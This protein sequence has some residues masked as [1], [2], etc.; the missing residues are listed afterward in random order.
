MFVFA[1]FH[2]QFSSSG[3]L[4]KIPFRLKNFW[5]I[6]FRFSPNRRVEIK[7]SQTKE[8]DPQHETLKTALNVFK[9]QNSHH[10]SRKM[11]NHKMCNHVFKTERTKTEVLKIDLQLSGVWK[12]KFRIEFLRSG[13]KKKKKKK[14]IW[15]TELQ[16]FRTTKTTTWKPK[17]CRKIFEVLIAKHLK[18]EILFFLLF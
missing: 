10:K 4:I 1:F 17:K 13:I 18:I 9:L 7:N 16:F 2:P 3:N 6:F 8:I 12:L 5:R 15:K 14:K 11:C